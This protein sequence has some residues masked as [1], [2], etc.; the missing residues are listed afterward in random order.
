MIL[1]GKTIVSVGEL[2]LCTI[3][4]ELGRIL[5]ES[6]KSIYSLKFGCT[7]S[8]N[9]NNNN[10]NSLVQF[11][12]QFVSFPKNGNLTAHQASSLSALVQLL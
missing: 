6:T 10:D 4:E 9:N 7:N 1:V 12:R 2:E 3:G 11:C 8:K 5:L